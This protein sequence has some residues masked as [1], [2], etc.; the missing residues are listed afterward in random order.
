MK[1]LRRLSLA[2]ALM[3]AIAAFAFAGE[4][5]SPPCVPGE[6]SGP[7]CPSAP[8]STDNSVAPG[9]QNGPPAANSESGFSFTDLVL[10]AAESVLLL[11]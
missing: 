10:D 8:A 9:E 1:N 5:N 4:M 3:L 7:P 6:M 11:F 2:L